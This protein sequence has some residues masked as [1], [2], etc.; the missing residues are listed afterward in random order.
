MNYEVNGRDDFEKNSLDSGDLQI[1]G[2][3]SNH[4]RL[5]NLEERQ[6]VVYSLGAAPTFPGSWK[7][8]GPGEKVMVKTGGATQLNFRKKVYY[9]NVLR[10]DDNSTRLND[11]TATVVVEQIDLY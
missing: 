3:A 1:T 10:N 2:I 8:L 4:L 9:R 6:D 7:P 5:T 11:V